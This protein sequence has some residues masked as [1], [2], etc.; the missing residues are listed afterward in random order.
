MLQGIPQTTMDSLQTPN[1]IGTI[2]ALAA[3]LGVAAWIINKRV[4]PE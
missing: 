1:L 3:M 4:R 2:V